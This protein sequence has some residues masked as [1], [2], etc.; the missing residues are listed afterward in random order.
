MIINNNHT[1]SR[2]DWKALIHYWGWKVRHVYLLKEHRLM[3][4]LFRY[5]LM[6]WSFLE[7]IELIYLQI[8]TLHC[9]WLFSKLCCSASEFY[10][11]C[12][13]FHVGWK[14][15]ENA[16]CKVYRQLTSFSLVILTLSQ[17][18]SLTSHVLSLNTRTQQMTGQNTSALLGRSTTITVELRSPSG[19]N[20]RTC[21]RGKPA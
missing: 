20:P 3:H 10:I 2:P 9:C 12:C 13:W 14:R 15:L 16:E 1:S 11:Y 6:L 21:W 8:L 4:T 17:Y 19:R 5:C 18:P 7:P